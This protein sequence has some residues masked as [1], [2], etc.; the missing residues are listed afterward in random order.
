MIPVWKEEYKKGV[1]YYRENGL[2]VGVLLW[3]VWD[4]VERVRSIIR[5]Q[6]YIAQDQLKDLL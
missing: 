3:N 1:I 4:K 2:I 5:K 6:Q